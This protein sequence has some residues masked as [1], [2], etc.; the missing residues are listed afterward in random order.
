MTE[1]EIKKLYESARGFEDVADAE[2]EAK[3]LKEYCETHVR[4][5]SGHHRPKADEEQKCPVRGSP[6]PYLVEKYPS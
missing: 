5:I 3:R 1:P 6:I 2:S 4:C